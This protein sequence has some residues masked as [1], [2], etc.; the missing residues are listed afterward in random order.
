[1]MDPKREVLSLEREGCNEDVCPSYEHG[2]LRTPKTIICKFKS[3]KS[4]RPKTANSRLCFRFFRQIYKK[5]GAVLL[6][7]GVIAWKQHLPP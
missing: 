3:D 4:D 1:M 5:D 2:F 6:N 7:L